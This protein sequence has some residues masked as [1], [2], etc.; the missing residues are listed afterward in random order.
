MKRLKRIFIIL[1]VIVVVAELFF[2]LSGKMYMNKLLANTVFKGRLGPTITEYHIYEN[3]EIK[4]ESPREWQEHSK[5][6][7]V[8]LEQQMLQRH[9]DYGSI[10]FAVFVDGKILYENYWDGF[11]DSSKTNSWS[12]AKSIISHLVGVALR[13]K[14]IESLDDPYSK[15]VK[16]FNTGTV[17][18]RQLLSMSSGIDFDENY[19]N[20]FSYPARSL[21]D[22][23][24]RE[25][26]V[27][28]ESGY[29]AGEYFDYQSGNTQLLAFLIE[30]VTGEKISDY[31]TEHLWGPI[32]ARYDALWSLDG[33]GGTERAFCCFNSNVRDFA[34]FG[35]LYLDSGVVNG[36]TLIDPSYFE[37]A[38]NAVDLIDKADNAPWRGYGYQWWIFD[39]ED[40]HVFYA[41]GLNGQYIF[42]IPEWNA[43]AVRL[44]HNWESAR[45]KKHQLDVRDYLKQTEYLLREA[46]LID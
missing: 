23:D 27:E 35:Q 9:L 17:T 43:V 12:M 37:M 20:P 18:I 10:G 15:Y 46:E 11:S 21:Y 22:S 2:L 1:A 44:G 39:E 31:A 25:I 16:G 28:Y 13:E 24:L 3:R 26:M 33:E 42:V 32:G 19:L 36:D 34:K 8:E 41:R 40:R 29:P 7:S 45:Y 30:D 4:A 6:M 5:Y 38:T 14:K